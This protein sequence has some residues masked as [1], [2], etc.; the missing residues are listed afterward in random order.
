MPW[1][2]FEPTQGVIDFLT[3]DLRDPLASTSTRISAEAA[4][5]STARI[6]RVAVGSPLLRF[7]TLGLTAGGEVLYRNVSFQSG[8]LL[9]VHISRQVTAP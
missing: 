5:P 4:D 8:D 1:W 9:D 7:V 2:S 6:L 3:P